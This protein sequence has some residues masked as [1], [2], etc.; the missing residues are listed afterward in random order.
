MN[1]DRPTGPIGGHEIDHEAQIALMQQRTNAAAAEARTAGEWFDIYWDIVATGV[2][3]ILE[4]NHADKTSAAAEFDKRMAEHMQFAKV[5]R[6]EFVSHG[7]PLL[8]EIEW[9]GPLCEHDEAGLPHIVSWPRGVWIEFF[10]PTAGSKG[11][12]LRFEGQAAVC[13]LGFIQWWVGFQQV[14][15]HMAGKEVEAKTRIIEPGSNEYVKYMAA[16]AKEQ[17]PS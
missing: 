12:K 4:A 11:D 7:L 6:R 14:G 9:E 10:W 3:H 1:A 16:K 17:K 2:R 5:V 8:E 15:A 13:A